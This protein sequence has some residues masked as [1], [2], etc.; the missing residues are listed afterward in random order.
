[1]RAPVFKTTRMKH[2]AYLKHI[3]PFGKLLLLLGLLLLF[4]V[5]TAFSGLLA[6]KL[7]LGESLTELG[8]L[9]ANPQTPEAVNFVK[10]FQLLN[11]IGI[12]V[13]PVI[14]YA[15]FVSPTPATYL[16]L[17]KKPS[18]VSLLVAGLVVYTILPFLNYVSE[19]NQDISLPASLAG[20]EDWMKAK[21][22]Q[23]EQLLRVFLKTDTLA[24]LGL[25]LLTVALVPAIG[26]ELLFRGVLLRLMKEITKSTHLAVV[27]SAILFSAVHLQ[28]FGFFPRFL[29][30]L[31][32]G[33]VFVFTGS[34]WVPV[35]LHLVNN[36]SS[37]V[38]YYLHHTGVIQIRMEDFG[39]TTNPVYVWGSLLITMWLMLVLYRNER[40]VLT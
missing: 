13:L 4:A 32:L 12:F 6:G 35:F 21:E 34:L 33:Y 1:M 18:A 39:A 8:S 29:L 11:Q 30:G 36:A 22:M 26:E 16:S 3:S 27:I 24:G 28:F 14:A 9:V 17:K 37:V 15:Y 23:A 7:Y 25:N 2:P 38:V 31:L 40:P 5:M 10:F 19:W 20:I